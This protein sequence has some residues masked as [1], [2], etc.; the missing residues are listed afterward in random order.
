MKSS[1][2]ISLGEALIDRLYPLEG[3]DELENTFVDCFGGA[4]AN[5]ACALSRLGAS[6]SFL[7]SVGNDEFGQKFKNL[8]IS[9]GINISG[10]QQDDFRPTRVVLVRRDANGERSF[11]GFDGDKGGGFADQAISL[12]KISRDWPLIAQRAQWLIVG[13][14]PLASRTSSEALLWCIKKS[15][16]SGIKI[17]I[18]VNWRPTFWRKKVS[19]LLAPSIDEQIKV[20]S[21]LKNASLIKLAKEEA[22]WFF[23]SNNPNEISSMLPQRPSVIITDGSNPVQWLL[24]KNIG[25]TI[26]LKPS[27]VIDT[28]GAGD[29][30]M[31]GLIYKLQHVEL[32]QISKYEAENII[33]FAICCGSYVCQGLGAIDS[34][35]HLQDVMRLLS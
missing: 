32:D 8:M 29:A 35:P 10:L 26:S 19:K 21:L 13:T 20:N 1:N 3:E 7:G 30:F 6:V 34:Q 15:I 23:N 4:P 28:T 24:N 31:A 14:I 27:E 22:N 18:D 33:Q 17:A 2:V 9:R 11:G 5:V 25:E 12:E 16:D